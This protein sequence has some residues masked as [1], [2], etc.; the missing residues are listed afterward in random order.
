MKTSAIKKVY[1]TPGIEAI[2]L[3]H[4]ISLALQS[5]PADPEGWGAK[6]DRAVPNPF[7]EEIA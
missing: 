4:E 3:D 6:L 7:K 5:L 2:P 1:S